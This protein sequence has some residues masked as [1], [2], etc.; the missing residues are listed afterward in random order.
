MSKSA[1]WTFTYILDQEGTQ[2][3][4]PIDSADIAY[5]IYEPETCPTTGTRHLQ[6]YVRFHNR[7]AL[8][9]AKRLLGEPSLHLEVAK[10]S[11]QQNKDYC[12]KEG[13]SIEFGNYEPHAGQQGRRNDLQE[14]QEAVKSGMPLKQVAANWPSQWIRYHQGITSFSLMIAP[15]PPLRRS[16]ITTVLWGTTGTGKS[17]R[18]RTAYPEAIIILPG[19]DPFYRYTNQPVIVFEEFNWA[20]WPIRKMNIYLDVW[21][22]DLDCRYNNKMALW[23]KVFILANSAPSSWYP[24][25]EAPLRDAFFRR[26]SYIVEIKNREQELLLI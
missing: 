6:G 18:V 10:G 7:K 9:T 3:M 23:E 20:D 17:H 11:E 19:R 1:R 14:L 2:W 16:V 21:S 22:A 15:T 26:L 5:I 13:H 24:M 8:A 4:P 25:E 12:S